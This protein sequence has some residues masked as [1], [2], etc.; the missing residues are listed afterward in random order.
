MLHISLIQMQQTRQ[1]GKKNTCF[2][3]LAGLQV[4]ECKV[5]VDTLKILVVYFLALKKKK[6]RREK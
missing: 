5:K 3:P 6:K 2:F 4:G 1:N